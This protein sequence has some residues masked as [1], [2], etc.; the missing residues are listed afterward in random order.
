MCSKRDFE[1]ERAEKKAEIE[2]LSA[3]LRTGEDAFW[4]RIRDL[5]RARGLEPDQ[6]VLAQLHTEDTNR[7]LGIVVAPNRRVFEFEYDHLHTPIGEGQ[8]SEWV[9]LTDLLSS[10]AFAG[11]IE[12]ALELVPRRPS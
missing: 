5:L 11:A 8:F 12:C 10:S 9:E 4:V 1:R 7:W 2:R 3:D 6:T